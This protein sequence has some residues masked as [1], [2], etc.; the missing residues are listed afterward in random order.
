MAQ[1]SNEAVTEEVV[2]AL[3]AGPVIAMELIARGIAAFANLVSARAWTSGVY[4]SRSIRAADRE[5][6]YFCRALAL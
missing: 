2:W 4:C 5:L 3:A 6:G 1:V